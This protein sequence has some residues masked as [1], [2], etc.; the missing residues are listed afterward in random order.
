MIQTSKPIMIIKGVYCIR[1][2]VTSELYDGKSYPRIFWFGVSQVMLTHPECSPMSLVWCM[3]PK[4]CTGLFVSGVGLHH[5]LFGAT[6]LEQ[7]EWKQCEKMS[8][9]VAVIL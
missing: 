6:P 4:L 9:I 5:S 7:G 1:R 2:N 8:K 3:M